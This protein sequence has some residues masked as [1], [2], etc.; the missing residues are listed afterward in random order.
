M[1]PV[2]S[3]R[4]VRQHR[5]WFV[6]GAALL[7][8]AP[9]I[10]AA[11]AET[12]QDAIA[13]AY[14]TNPTLRQNRFQ[15]KS[16]DENYVQAR[17]AYGPTL[18]FTGQAID[19]QNAGFQTSVDA[20]GNL[21]QNFLTGY[22]N[23]GS[24]TLNL[25]Q[26]LYTG[27]QLR[28][29]LAQQRAR[30]LSGQQTLRNIE[31]QVLQAVIATYAAVIR[32]EARVKV[33][34]EN[35]KV[36]KQQRDEKRSR[37]AQQDV[38][39]TDVAQAEAR[40]AD[41]ENQLGTIIASLDNSRGQYLQI[42]GHDP[43]TLAPLPD[44]PGVPT[45]SDEAYQ[46]AEANNPQL[47][48]SKYTEQASSA[49]VATARGAGKPN[50][51]L[52]AQAG[53]VGQL[54]PFDSRNYNRTV[55]GSIT[56]TQP[57]FNG[58]AIRSRIRQA[59]D[60]NQ[61]DQA[62]VDGARRTAL[63]SVNLAW[64]QLYSARVGLNVGIRQ[65]EFAQIAFAGM[66][67]EELA[68]YRDAIET[69]NAEQELFNAELN[70]LANR[71][72]EYVARAGLLAAVGDLTAAKLTA[73]LP[74]YDPEADFRKVRNRGRTPLEPI[75]QALDRIGSARL[76]QP[77]SADLTGADVPP[78]AV[79]PPLLKTPDARLMQSPLTP[80]TESPV[81]PATDL[82]RGYVA[83]QPGMATTAAAAQNPRD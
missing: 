82:P 77:L 60:N 28:G 26:P 32:D 55:A 7:L 51:A 31:E 50:V 6:L 44:L 8:L 76:R 49:A 22:A 16:L 10:Q 65:V 24:A 79:M 2:L 54:S 41:G 66:R 4:L 75:A 58:G 37:L 14:E 33:A 12:L 80:I 20:D 1:P 30:V 73:D 64:T 38:T 29:Q 42:V 78:A 11:R 40:L 71:Y 3:P 25:N 59:I 63:Q 9:T 13:A 17:A 53:Y 56:V 72:N 43:G 39:A 81:V 35:V 19:Q 61:S 21:V 18:S 68:G 45:S 15:L 23:Q 34:E 83:P 69:L 62:G 57:L 27:G 46:R 74:L 36:L 70:F 52:N 48:A 5:P 47:L 67:H